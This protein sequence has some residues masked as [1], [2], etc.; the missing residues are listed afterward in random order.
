[1]NV[2]NQNEINFAF[3]MLI[4]KFSQQH[5]HWKELIKCIIKYISIRYTNDLMELVINRVRVPEDEDH[6]IQKSTWPATKYERCVK[7]RLE[8]LFLVFRELFLEK[9]WANLTPIVCRD[10][11]KLLQGFQNEIEVSTPFHTREYEEIT[12]LLW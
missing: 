9:L 8:N 1:M 2:R 12:W 5:V 3:S 4:V 10:A 7:K 11:Y 6:F